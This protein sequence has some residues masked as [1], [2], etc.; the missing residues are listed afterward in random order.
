MSQEDLDSSIGGFIECGA[1]QVNG[2]FLHCQVART[3]KADGKLDEEFSGYEAAT[4]IWVAAELLTLNVEAVT[5]SRIHSKEWEFGSMDNCQGLDSFSSSV[6][7]TRTPEE[8]R[9]RG[10]DRER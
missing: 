3:Y 4:M 9:A 7:V 5:E 2:L 8:K 1:V 6:K 10:G